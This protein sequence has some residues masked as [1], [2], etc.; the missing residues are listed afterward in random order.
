MISLKKH[1]PF[2]AACFHGNRSSSQPQSYQS[3]CKFPRLSVENIVFLTSCCRLMR[4]TYS[5]SAW[6]ACMFSFYFIFALSFLIE[7]KCCILDCDLPTSKRQQFRIPQFVPPASSPTPLTLSGLRKG[8]VDFLD[9]RLYFSPRQ[10]KANFLFYLFVCFGRTRSSLLCVGFLQLHSS[11]GC[12]LVAMC[13][14]LIAVASLLAEHGLQGAQA[15]VVAAH[16]FSI[17][18][19]FSGAQAQ[20]LWHRAQLL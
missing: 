11:T 18:G 5:A 14:L 6:T 12:S 19:L 9:E 2:L 17:Q 8:A 20:Q 16:W 10:S 15:S 4:E 7:S 3:A 13:R 1:A